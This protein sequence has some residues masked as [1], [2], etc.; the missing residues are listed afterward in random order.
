MR[1]MRLSNECFHSLV[2]HDIFCRISPGLRRSCWSGLASAPSFKHNRQ[3]LTGFGFSVSWYGAKF[4]GGRQ[5]RD[6][7]NGDLAC[8]RYLRWQCG[9]RNNQR[10]RG[11]HLAGYFARIRTDYCA[12]KK[13]RGQFQNCVRRSNRD[14]RRRGF[15]FTAGDAGGIGCREVLRGDC[16]LRRQSRSCGQLDRVRKR[17]CRNC[18]WLGR[19]CGNLHGAASSYCSAWRPGESHQRRG[20][21]EEWLSG[22]HGHE[23][24]YADGG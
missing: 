19:L 6:E 16:E 17:L 10:E 24:F 4:H 5:Q 23:F 7:Y 2:A 3:R 18:L 22:D 8:E 15:R 14:Q 21:V 1:R 11:L 9:C 13:R 12:G 20:P